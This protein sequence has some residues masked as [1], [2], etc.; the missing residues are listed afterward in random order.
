[1]F[2]VFAFLITG[3]YVIGASE[4]ALLLFLID[5]VNSYISEQCQAAREPE[6]WDITYLARVAV[7]LES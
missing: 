7:L 2:L 4:I 6:S 5:F 3:Q 1:M